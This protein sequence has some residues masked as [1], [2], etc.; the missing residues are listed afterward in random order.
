M[1]K[2][3]DWAMKYRTALN[4]NEFLLL[5]VAFLSYVCDGLLSDVCAFPVCVTFKV[6]F[7]DFLVLGIDCCGIIFRI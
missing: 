1:A 7:S 2:G 5:P 4:I 6:H 3:P